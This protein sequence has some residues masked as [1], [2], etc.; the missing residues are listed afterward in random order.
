MAGKGARTSDDAAATLR[1]DKW[2]WQARFFKSRA[3]AVEIIEGGRVR[4]NGQKTRKAGHVLRAGDVLTFPQADVIRVIRV[5]ALGQR[6]GPASEAQEL[7]QDVDPER[8]VAAT[9]PIE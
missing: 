2:L 7:Y 9:P 5:L 4:I 8:A 6:R 3:L 1:L